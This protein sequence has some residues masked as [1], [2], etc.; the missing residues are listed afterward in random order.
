MNLTRSKNFILDEL[1]TTTTSKDLHYLARKQS[2]I[3][4]LN[5]AIHQ[6]ESF[7]L[8]NNRNFPVSGNDTAVCS[9]DENKQRLKLSNIAVN[10][11][12]SMTFENTKNNTKST[13][14]KKNT[15]NLEIE[16]VDENGNYF[17]FNF[18]S[19]KS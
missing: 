1:I 2:T 14:K 10:N 9:L 18:Y 12:N 19:S 13:I 8:N 15:E 7:A 17:F 5:Q 3:L 4:L 6:Q 11:H 16:D